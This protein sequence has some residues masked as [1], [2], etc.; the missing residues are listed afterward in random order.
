[1]KE[2]D[3][4]TNEPTDGQKLTNTFSQSCADAAK[5]T[6]KK[7]KRKKE[8][9]KK[10]KKEKAIQFMKRCDVVENEGE[11]LKTW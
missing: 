4:R 2:S 6:K 1:M 5:V 9:K 3:G 7:K 8:K 10:D 11:R